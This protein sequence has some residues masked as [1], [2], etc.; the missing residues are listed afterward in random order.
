[1]NPGEEYKTGFVT[2]H[3]QYVYLRIGQSFLGAPHTNFQF[4]DMVFEHLPKTQAT[5]SQSSP[6]EYHA[7]RRFSLF[8]DDHI[9]ATIFFEAMF[10]FLH[11][12]YFS[13]TIFGPVC[14]APHKTFIFTDQLDF[15]GFT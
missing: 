13:R 8:M 3:G 7:D 2:A 6:H 9:G 1:M 5:P 12:H 15:I 11:H 14:L 4:S 10:E